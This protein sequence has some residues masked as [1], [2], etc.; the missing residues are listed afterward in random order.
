MPKTIHVE[1]MRGMAR[2]QARLTNN[3][4]HMLTD[5]HG[6]CLDCAIRN[7]VAF[8][9]GLDRPEHSP[10][11]GAFCSEAC[12]DALREFLEQTLGCKPEPV[13]PDEWHPGLAQ[14]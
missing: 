9:W 5:K 10:T 4:A 2:K 13:G 8:V 3:V 1:A 14:H 12:G 6:M 7:A 11:Y